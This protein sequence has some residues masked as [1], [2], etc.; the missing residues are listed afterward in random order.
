MIKVRTFIALEPPISLWKELSGG[1]NLIA[2]Q[3][4]RQRIRWN[5]QKNTI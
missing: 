4:K 1:A 5:L 2:G 3:D